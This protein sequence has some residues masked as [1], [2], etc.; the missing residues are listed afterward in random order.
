M[1]F[2][3]AK[4]K[5]MAV[6]IAVLAAVLT[7]ANADAGVP[8][9]AQLWRG[10]VSRV[11]S[12]RTYR[13]N[14][15]GKALDANAKQ[16]LLVAVEQG[17]TVAEKV[18]QLLD[19]K[20]SGTP[21]TDPA[22]RRLARSL[23]SLSMTKGDK[24]PVT[25]ADFAVQAIVA[26]GLNQAVGPARLVGEEDATALRSF[27]NRRMRQ[28]VVE[29][30]RLVDPTISSHEVLAAIDM[31]NDKAK[32]G[33]HWTLD[34]IDGT[35]GFLRSGQYAIS[36]GRIQ[37]GQLDYGILASPN[38]SPNPAESPADIHRPGLI[39]MAEKGKGAQVIAGGDANATPQRLSMKP[40]GKRTLPM[41]ARVEG[42]DASGLDNR[43]LGRILKRT[44]PVVAMDSASKYAAAVLHGGIYFRGG[45]PGGGKIWDHSAGVLVAQEAGMKVTDLDGKPL[46]FGLGIHLSQNRGILVAPPQVHK[47][48]RDALSQIAASKSASMEATGA[49]A[50]N[51]SPG[52]EVAAESRFA[53]PKDGRGPVKSTLAATDSR[54]PGIDER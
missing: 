8:T 50:A 30:V 17:R 37:N 40:L 49:N 7:T 24:S 31:G 51:E 5:T 48:V 46:N 47:Q 3:I 23:E 53:R 14:S 19:A 28:A 34:P 9:P 39:F 54:E 21:I 32:T 33:N 13:P 15:V 41:V 38:L 36:L 43:T 22:M 10:V 16:T 35:K 6:V 52:S 1:K 45:E 26:R 4:G 44:M 25:I 2:E 11:K 20:K 29:A 18:Q 42:S 27:K 12:L